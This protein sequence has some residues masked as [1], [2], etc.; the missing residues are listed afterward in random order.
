[1]KLPKIE[2]KSISYNPFGEVIEEHTGKM[3]KF[4]G[5]KKPQRF[6]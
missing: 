5:I 1:M 6:C 2:A 4:A 3:E